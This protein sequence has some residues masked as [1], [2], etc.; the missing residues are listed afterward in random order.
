[1]TIQ[2]VEEGVQSRVVG[3]QLDQTVNN[4][5]PALLAEQPRSARTKAL[6]RC[7]R[8]GSLEH[9]ARTCSS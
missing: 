3:K 5:D 9:N 7:S 1:M 8:Y 6:G 2:Q 4:I